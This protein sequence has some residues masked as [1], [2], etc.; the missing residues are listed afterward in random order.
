MYQSYISRVRKMKEASGLSAMVRSCMEY[1]STH[2][3]DK[4][5][6]ES[7]ADD[8]GYSGTYIS[9]RFKEETGT[10]PAEYIAGEKIQ[11]AKDI[12]R[13]ENI[14]ISQLSDRL[15]DSSP[16]Y[17]SALFKKITGITP[18]EYQNQGTD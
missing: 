14:T 2:I 7:I 3:F 12:L 11:A 13:S 10:A 17:F 5:S 1:I 18:Q 16:D 6:L 8:P 4:I 9:R 15:N